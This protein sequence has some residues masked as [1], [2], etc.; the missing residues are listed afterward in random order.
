MIPETNA[1]QLLF[2]FSSIFPSML[3]TIY[4]EKVEN[5]NMPLQTGSRNEM[6]L[7][8]LTENKLDQSGM[9]YIN[10]NLAVILQKR[11]ENPFITFA[12]HLSQIK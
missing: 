6:C 1:P 3:L 7:Q 2:F 5:C 12:W 11:E 4:E 9:C 8:K 10:N